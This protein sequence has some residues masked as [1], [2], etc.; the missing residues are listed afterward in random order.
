MSTCAF[1]SK[2]TPELSLKAYTKRGWK[3]F[4]KGDY[5][6]NIIGIRANDNKANT[7][8]DLICL[9]YKVNDKW[10][11][12]KYDATTDP[13]LYYRE[14]PINVNGTAILKD[15]CYRNSFGI[16]LHHGKYR[17]LVQIKPLALWRNNNKNSTLDFNGKTTNEMAEIHI[18]RATAS[19]VSK[20]VDKWSA[21]CQVIASSSDYA[22]FMRIIDT[23]TKYF[24]PVFSYAL[25]TENDLKG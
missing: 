14:H 13:G 1:S 19:G 2:V 20:Y 17:C 5:N 11:L 4:T 9:L 7:F 18:H 21:G 24:K 15:G 25:F 16:G 12:K 3:P 10:T 22:E 8:N 23:S 6:L